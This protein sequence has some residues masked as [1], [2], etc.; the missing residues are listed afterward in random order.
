MRPNLVVLA[1]ACVRSGAL[2]KRLCRFVRPSATLYSTRPDMRPPVAVGWA[3]AEMP[4]SPLYNSMTPDGP[5]DRRTDKAS[6]RVACP[7]LKTWTPKLYAFVALPGLLPNLSLQYPCDLMISTA[8][9]WCFISFCL[10][11]NCRFSNW[12]PNNAR[13]LIHFLYICNGLN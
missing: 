12:Q 2:Y 3:G 13:W 1:L 11:H 8:L 6:Y 9:A 4:V 7:Q 5:T 10:G